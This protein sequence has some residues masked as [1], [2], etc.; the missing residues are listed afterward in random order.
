[1]SRLILS[2]PRIGDPAGNSFSKTIA[3]GTV[4]GFE[5][6]KYAMITTM[7]AATSTTTSSH[8]D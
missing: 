3:D 8:E 6:T 5:N 4:S 7:T 1:M 2:S